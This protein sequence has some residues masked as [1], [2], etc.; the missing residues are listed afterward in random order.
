MFDLIRAEWLKLTKRPLTW[1]LL[2]IF[3]GGLLLEILLYS[4][5]VE[6]L[7]LHIRPVGQPT[8]RLGAFSEMPKWTQFP[9]LFGFVFSQIN[10][11]G[12]IFAVIL[13]AASMGNEYSW[14][15]LRTQLAR[16]PSRDRYLIAKLITLL[17]LLLTGMIVSLVVGGVA[18]GVVAALSGRFGVLTPTD[19]L[20]VAVSLFRA[21]Y[22]FLP[23]LLLTI[24]ITIITRSALVGAGVGIIYIAFEVSFGAL[25]KIFSVL[26][27]IWVQI[28][29]LTIQQNIMTL[30]MLNGNAFGLE[31]ESA[32]GIDPTS[33]PS[34]FQA[35]LVIAVY[36]ISFWLTARYW[37]VRR[38][39]TGAL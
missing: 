3:L 31:S 27:D 29:N 2:V 32:V 25:T 23:Y 10:G 30:T 38:D 39:V 15:T 16:Q 24:C 26:G 37:F 21:L 12:G 7:Q 5:A 6:L 17:A 36:S 35:V 19:I 34:P 8:E 4:V 33:L 13:A 1:I 20:M 9:G 22:V 14:G 18:G 28:Y 11:L